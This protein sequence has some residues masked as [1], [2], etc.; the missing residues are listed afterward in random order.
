VINPVLDIYP[1]FPI[2]NLSPCQGYVR[3]SS[4]FVDLI[5]GLP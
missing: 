4:A 5:S 1:A 2:F 3:K